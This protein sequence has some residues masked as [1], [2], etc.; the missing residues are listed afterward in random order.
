MCLRHLFDV[1]NIGTLRVLITRL[2]CLAAP[3]GGAARAYR[4]PDR[5]PLWASFFAP[6]TPAEQVVLPI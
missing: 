5:G 1:Q 2:W 3:A 6:L 4:G